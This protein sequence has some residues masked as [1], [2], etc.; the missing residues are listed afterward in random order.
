MATSFQNFV[1]K[2]LPKRLYTNINPID[3]SANLVPY[4][5]GIGLGVEFMDL[6][7]LKDGSVNNIGTGN[8]LI[9]SGRDAS[10]N[11]LL[12]TL[13]GVSPITVDT[14]GNTVLIGSNLVTGNYVKEASLGNQFYWENDYLKVT[15]SDTSDDPSIN[16]LYEKVGVYDYD[17]S[18]F[19][20]LSDT[21]TKSISELDKIIALLTPT[22]PD[23]LSNKNLSNPGYYSANIESSFISAS[24]ITDDNTPTSTVN[25]FL[26]E[27]QTNLIAYINGNS[28]GSIYITDT[29]M[30][31]TSNNSLSITNDQDAYS[32]DSQREG[33]YR[34][35]S[36]TISSNNI[37]DASTQQY[38]YNL[39]YPDS[40][41]E[42]DTVSFYIDD[43][44]S[45]SISNENLDAS[46]NNISRYISGVPSYEVD[47]SIGISYS[48]DNA[49]GKFYHPTTLG[50]ANL[51]AGDSLSSGLPGT[52]PSEG[53]NI[54]FTG[55]VLSFEDN[56]YYENGNIEVT[57]TPYRSNGAY[58]S[59]NTILS[60]PGRIDTVSDESDRVTSGDNS[61]FP[62][63]GYGNIYDST[64]SLK[65]SS[66]IAE[67]QKLNNLYQWPESDYSV[68]EGGPDYSTGLGTSTRWVTFSTTISNLTGFDIQ[69]NNTNNFTADSQEV[70]QNIKIYA[71]V[72]GAEPTNG[73]IDC[74][75]P[76]P[77]TGNPTD[78]G[79]A[80]MKV[81]NSSATFKSITFGSTTKIGTLYVRI[82]LEPGSTLSF[83]DIIIS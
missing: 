43:P 26:K 22:T 39:Q 19:I 17:S 55:E 27:L 54:T 52:A 16:E 53:D 11:I 49:I 32:G 3:V 9:S 29:D 23:K 81:L 13:K 59:G 18:N 68:W 20:S 10:G 24:N 31:G 25:S 42:T 64:V 1:N 65:V 30:S 78:D 45:P 14:S 73:W 60:I 57:I 35:L 34:V 15:I 61:D 33:F 48:V 72:D 71:N 47:N 56:Q 74:N 76:Y 79:D 80:G 51:N 67:L 44:T 82:G 38:N 63:S 28:D 21:H 37:L 75:A 2:E 12:R 70:T 6:F 46:V 83:E 66:Y 40:N 8:G 58:S 5:T 4:T 36:A 7:D 62:T 77:G 69:F 41:N 50:E